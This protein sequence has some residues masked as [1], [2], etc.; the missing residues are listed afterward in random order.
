MTTHKAEMNA[1]PRSAD[2]LAE[3]I[4]AAPGILADDLRDRDKTVRILARHAT[5]HLP[6]PA[7]AFD[8]MIYRLVVI[9]LGSVVMLSTVGAII[10]S[11]IAPA[12]ATASTPDVVTALGSAAIGALA[13]L[14]APS[15]MS[16]QAS[17]E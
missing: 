7:L 12:G 17:S 16:R 3:L 13:G 4:L 15:P 2:L 5:R 1:I 14:L 6:P 11:A 8:S 9:F 10:L